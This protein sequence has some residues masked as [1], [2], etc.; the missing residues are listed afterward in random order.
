MRIANRLYTQHNLLTIVCIVSFSKLLILP[1]DL[2][3]K[4]FFSLSKFQLEGRE[5]A[6]WTHLNAGGGGTACLGTFT[7][8]EWEEVGIPVAPLPPPHRQE[9]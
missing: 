5:G 4:Y 7:G 3:W 6:E 8:S 2:Q 1:G 9:S